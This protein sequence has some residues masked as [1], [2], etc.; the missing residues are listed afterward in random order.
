MPCSPSAAACRQL[1]L[2]SS[3]LAASDPASTDRDSSQGSSSGNPQKASSSKPHDSSALRDCDD[4]GAA[5]AQEAVHPAAAQ[6]P[7]PED[8]V[9]LSHGKLPAVVVP[10][11]IELQARAGGPWQT[12][13]NEVV[14]ASARLPSASISGPSL[15]AAGLSESAVSLP[16]LHS[17]ADGPAWCSAEADNSA[18]LHQAVISSN[19]TAMPVGGHTAEEPQRGPMARAMSLREAYGGTPRGQQVAAA[20]GLQ[21]GGLPS[22]QAPVRTASATCDPPASDSVACSPGEFPGRLQLPSPV[23]GA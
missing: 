10:V 9:S 11:R 16:G 13:R 18:L 2:D 7:V 4:G 8:D 6:T 19:G 1:A 12:P 5:P 21:T 20:D 22:R 23:V 15:P 3:R 14:A 17:S